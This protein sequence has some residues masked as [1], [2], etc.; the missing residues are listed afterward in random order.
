MTI[1]NET[2]AE[3]ARD[4]QP[5]IVA[6][7]LGMT[8]KEVRDIAKGAGV[9]LRHYAESRLGGTDARSE[10]MKMLERLYCEEGLTTKQVHER[11]GYNIVYLNQ[12]SNHFGW[13]K[14]QN[15]HRK[16]RHKA[17]EICKKVIAVKA[18]NQCSTKSALLALGINR[19]DVGINQWIKK[20]KESGEL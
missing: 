13:P 4:M 9:K 15:R 18:E 6:R 20:F 19:S 3:L 14:I 7:K 1:S 2:V 16:V 10:R 12:I 8:T 11:T 5:S 17:L